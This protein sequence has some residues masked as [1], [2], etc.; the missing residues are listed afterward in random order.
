VGSASPRPPIA[1]RVIR[2]A[3]LVAGRLLFR[4][5]LKGQQN[6]PRTLAGRPAGG[7]ICAGVPH[8]TW[9]EPFALFV[10]LPARPRL[11]ML[12]D[13]PVM[14]RSGWRRFL[15]RRVGGVVPIWRGAGAVGFRAH[16]DAA[17]QAISA[18]SVFALFPEVGPPSR[19]PEPRRLSRGIAHI[20]IHTG[21]PIVPVVFGGTHEL[22]LR[23]RVVVRVLPPIA[24]IQPTEESGI[25]RAVDQ[26]MGA[27]SEAVRPAMAEAHREAEPPP[28]RR[29]WLRALTGPYGGGNG[30]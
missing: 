10:L 7:W 16:L 15:I 14:F 17:R 27:Y 20:A 29:K 8:R 18:G 22:F 21:A 1:Y 30:G 13:G 23:R 12:A 2:A 26:L 9:I 4:L 6:L 28:G 25:E 24:P 19:P 11:V 5:E 3:F